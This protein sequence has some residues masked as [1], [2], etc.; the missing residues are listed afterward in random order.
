MNATRTLA[1]AGVKEYFPQ[2]RLNWYRSPKKM[3]RGLAGDEVK[4]HAETYRV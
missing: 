1:A 3:F 4:Y 2:P